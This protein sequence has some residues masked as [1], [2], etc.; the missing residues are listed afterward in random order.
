MFGQE[1]EVEV[2]TRFLLKF[3]QYFAADVWLTLQNWILVKIPKLGL[4]MILNLDLVEMLMCGWR[5]DFE[6]NV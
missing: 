6:V 5:W 4:V 3:G 2:Q 1:F